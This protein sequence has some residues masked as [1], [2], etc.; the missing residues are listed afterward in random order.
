[1]R[2]LFTL[3]LAALSLCADS[4]ILDRPRVLIN[5]ARVA[6]LVSYADSADP[7]V[8]AKY[9]ALLTIL[10]PYHPYNASFTSGAVNRGADFALIYQMNKQ[11]FGGT[12]NSYADLAKD[13]GILTI[14]TALGGLSTL[15]L[16]ATA[17]TNG[18]TPEITLSG[19]HGLAPGAQKSVVVAGG[20]GTW[21]KLQGAGFVFTAHASDNTKGTIVCSTLYKWTPCD[22]DTTSLGSLSG[23]N[24]TVFFGNYATAYPNNLGG[25][26]GQ[27]QARYYNRG[28][29]QIYDWARDGVTIDDDYYTLRNYLMYQAAMWDIRSNTSCGAISIGSNLCMGSLTGGM[30]AALALGVDWEESGA[31]RDAQSTYDSLRT[32][33]GNRFGAITSR[34]STPPGYLSDGQSYEGAEYGPQTLPMHL[35]VAETIFTGTGEDVTSVIGDWP[36][37]I[38]DALIHNT[39]SL[40]A[41][42]PMPSYPTGRN[43]YEPVPFA[44]ILMQNQG[45]FSLD[46]IR[47]GTIVRYYAVRTSNTTE[48]ERI[49]FWMAN[50]SGVSDT[51]HESISTNFLWQVTGVSESNDYR[52]SLP[53]QKRDIGLNI[54]SARDSFT[55]STAT[56]SYLTVGP[57]NGTHSHG[58]PGDFGINRKGVWLTK[59]WTGWGANAANGTVHNIPYYGLLWPATGTTA[60]GDPSITHYD[61]SQSAYTYARVQMAKPYRCPTSTSCNPTQRV[62]TATRYWIYIRPSLVVVAD[63]VNYLASYPSRYML[64]FRQQPTVNSNV[65][66]YVEG[67]QELTATV[68]TPASMGSVVRDNSKGYLM[69]AESSGANTL[70]WHDYYQNTAGTKTYEG[71]T[72]D[73]TDLNAGVSVPA[74]NGSNTGIHR[75]L[76][77]TA[78][79]N[80]SAFAAFGAQAVNR[81]TSQFTRIAASEG[82]DWRVE[83]FDGSGV[84]DN[85]TNDSS[86]V[87]LEAHDDASTATAHDAITVTTGNWHGRQINGSYKVVVMAPNSETVDA[88]L[89][90][91]YSATV[92]LTHHIVGLTPST[93]YNVDLGTSGTVAITPCS[94]CANPVG[95]NEAG[96]LRFGTTDGGSASLL[97][98]RSPSTLSFSCVAGGGAPASQDIS[99]NATGGVAA[100]TA[101]KVESWLS[102][103]GA[104]GSTT[105]TVTATPSCPGMPGVYTDTITISSD[106]SVVANSPL[107]VG[108]TLTATGNTLIPTPSSLAFVAEVGGVTPL[109]QNIM[110]ST[111]LPVDVNV[112]DDATWLS[113][114][115]SSGTVPI[116]T[117][118]TPTLGALS[119]GIH[120]ATVTITAS[121]GVTNSPVTVPVSFTVT[122]STSSTSTL[123]TNSDQLEFAVTLGGP[124]PVTQYFEI[125]ASP[126]NVEIE[127]VVSDPHGIFSITPSGTITPVTYTVGVDTSDLFPGVYTA[128]VSLNPKAAGPGIE[129]TLNL[130]VT[131]PGRMTLSVRPLSTQAIMTYG[132]AGLS[133][134][135]TCILRVLQSPATELS[136]ATD[137]GGSARRTYVWSTPVLT[138]LTIGNQFEAMCGT[139]TDSATFNTRPIT[140]GL[141][142]MTVSSP[143]V[144][145]GASKVK[146]HWGYTPALSESPVTAMCVS[147]HCRSSIPVLRDR[148]VYYRREF[149]NSSDIIVAGPSAITMQDVR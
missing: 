79:L 82:T 47:T 35:Q 19:S 106:P 70:L 3:I 29:S 130:V 129:V 90:Y 132:S 2:V 24:I 21:A 20:M 128:T 124:A 11:P 121:G 6:Q 14:K 87:V 108:V 28:L 62:N 91:T 57:V 53:L 134:S 61:E 39:S 7:T 51:G 42:T 86:L 118:C 49:S 50:L 9:N 56:W 135:Q 123:S 119:A 149:L 33:W 16:Q 41:K 85:K 99:V 76:R 52:A 83:Y 81:L 71:A 44:D 145:S 12:R 38:V 120:N 122:S 36:L 131:A 10:D 72:G 105:G 37:R 54:V 143:A 45:H 30:F 43:H 100:Y 125:A 69:H 104:T 32:L 40:P 140:S 107:T 22:A 147:G 65:I 89:T 67:D 48:A 102:L 5:D 31:T 142:I 93:N 55:S 23:Q 18:A 139:L 92:A 4:I 127:A 84:P 66:T 114:S 112:S 94:G 88:S 138:P 80:S 137:S 136:R 148:V 101:T 103:S 64:H 117:T 110:I 13:Y 97:I 113:C 133:A 115:P 17:I 96:V 1:M 34:T 59:E 144:G 46:W 109:S 26:H 63:T 75:F 73:W 111:T 58:A 68:V 74:I 60:S 146:I 77:P 78:A 25:I 126:S 141:T 116:T 8:A 95:T 98:S 27:N 15:S